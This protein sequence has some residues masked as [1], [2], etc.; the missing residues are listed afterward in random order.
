MVIGKGALIDDFGAEFHQSLKEAF[1]HSN[2]GD[3][4]N[5]ESTEIGERLGFTRDHIFQMERVMGAGKDAGVAVVATDLFFEGGM[6]LALAF[7]EENEVGAFEGVGRFAENAAGKNVTVAEGILAVHEEKI[8]T[9]AEAEVLVAIVKKEGIGAVVA[10]GVAGRFDAV[11]INEDGDTGKV[12][13]EHEGFVAGLGRVEQDG[14]SIGYDPGRRGSAAG[15]E[16]IGESGEEGFGDGFIAAAEN[17]DA[18][19][20]FLEGAGELFDDGGF[21]GAAHG[22]V[23]DADDEGTDGVTAEDGVVIEAGAEA[24][25]AGVDGGEEKEEGFEEG[26]AASG[27]PIENDVRGELLERFEGFQ[28][29]RLSLEV[30]VYVYD[31]VYGWGGSGV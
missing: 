6:V 22:E 30:F 18:A 1:G 14:F 17:G 26:G 2:A 15:E 23:T 19:T 8:E 3:G 5:P 31:Y 7:G 12:A 13:G 16:A 10:D 9:V 29:H 11:G 25:D 21:A 4:A 28:G 24:H 20:G 27:R